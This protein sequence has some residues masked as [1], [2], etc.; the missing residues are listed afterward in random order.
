MVWAV[1]FVVLFCAS[2]CVRD[3]VFVAIGAAIWLL[4]L[5]AMM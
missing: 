3:A 5:A 1:A 4:L 2:R